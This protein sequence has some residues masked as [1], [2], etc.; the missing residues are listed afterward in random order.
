MSRTPLTGEATLDI[1]SDVVPDPHPARHDV[2]V[3]EAVQLGELREELR[4]RVAVHAALDVRQLALIDQFQT[5]RPGADLRLRLREQLGRATLFTDPRAEGDVRAKFF[6]L[7]HLLAILSGFVAT[8]LV[9]TK[10][11]Y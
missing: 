4:V 1:G 3:R 7:G 11:S 10:K 2:A 6:C 5:S 9:A 8:G